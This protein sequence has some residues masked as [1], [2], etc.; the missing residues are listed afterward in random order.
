MSE[1]EVVLERQWMLLRQLLKT[2]EGLTLCEMAQMFKVSEKTIKRDLASL[3]KVFGP[4]RAK[5]EAHGRKRYRYESQ[6]L[7]FDEILDHME[8][9]ALYLGLK[10][11]GALE[12]TE[13]GKK[14]NSSRAKIERTLRSELLDF[15]NRV[16]PL[17]RH[18]G[19]YS[20]E[21]CKAIDA[22]CVGL[23]HNLVLNLTYR[24]LKS[25]EEK[26]YEV[27]PY[28]FYYRDNCV[29]LVGLCCDDHRVKFWKLERMSKAEVLEDRRFRFPTDFNPDKHLRN[30]VETV[31]VPT[32]RFT[33]FAARVVPEEQK[34]RIISLHRESDDAIVCKM[35][36][37][38][39]PT[40]YNF[41]NMI[42]Y[43]GSHAEILDP[44]EL[45]E[46]FKAKVE[47]LRQNYIAS[48]DDPVK[49]YKKREE[50]APLSSNTPTSEGANEKPDDYDEDVS[51]PIVIDDLTLLGKKRG[52]G[53]PRK[54][55]LQISTAPKKRGRPR[56]YPPIEPPRSQEK[57]SEE[58]RK[59]PRPLTGAELLRRLRG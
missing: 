11:T 14:A 25:R 23:R 13:I 59:R 5:N 43:Y 44:P 2:P 46:K 55:P 8:L 42:M 10:L 49:Y 18:W 48:G 26:T 12:G 51:Y 35:D 36:F 21:V 30:G 50:E 47:E 17:C 19:A 32:I 54:Y 38:R 37:E 40:F 1:Y 29:Y 27:C 24:S 20:E 31:G 34:D 7:N 28:K 58:R 6:S 4:W 52:R 9:F 53:R 41:F 22:I 57:P 33:G 16:A 45:R 3:R 39:L 15:A 56:K